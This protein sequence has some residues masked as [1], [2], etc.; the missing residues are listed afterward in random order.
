MEL[1][2]TSKLIERVCERNVL[3]CRN[4]RDTN[5]GEND[6]LNQTSCSSILVSLFLHSGLVADV[7]LS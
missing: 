5:Q 6:E 7:L 4:K 2:A 3:S 1:P